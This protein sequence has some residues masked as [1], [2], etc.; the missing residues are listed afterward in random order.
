MYAAGKQQILR[1]AKDDKL[2]YAKDDKS[3]T[4]QSVDRVGAGASGSTE[5][6]R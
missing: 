6:S 5:G 4:N 2:S 1:Y 3:A